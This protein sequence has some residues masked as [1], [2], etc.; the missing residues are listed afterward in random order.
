MKKQHRRF[1]WAFAPFALAAAAALAAFAAGCGSGLLDTEDKDESFYTKRVIVTSDGGLSGTYGMDGRA[2]RVAIT[3]SN[4]NFSR[5]FMSRVNKATETEPIDVTDYFTVTTGTATQLLQSYTFKAITPVTNTLPDVGSTVSRGS[6]TFTA[7][8]SYKICGDD[9]LLE[10]GATS[11]AVKIT[12]SADVLDETTP[13]ECAGS[14]S[15]QFTVPEHELLSPTG[16]ALYWAVRTIEQEKLEGLNAAVLLTTM[17]PVQ[18]DFEQGVQIGTATGGAQVYA[19]KAIQKGSGKIFAVVNNATATESRYTGSVTIMLCGGIL[20][21][22]ETSRN[23]TTH[24]AATTLLG[25]LYG[26]DF[27]ETDGDVD[28]VAVGRYITPK[29]LPDGDGGFALCEDAKPETGWRGAYTYSDNN[30]LW[31]VNYDGSYVVEFDLMLDGIVS[32]DGRNGYSDFYL[33]NSSVDLSNELRANPPRSAMK[34]T[35]WVWHFTGEATWLKSGTMQHYKVYVNY[36][37]AA[38]ASTVTVEVDGKVVETNTAVSGNGDVQGVLLEPA[39]GTAQTIDNI[40]I[41]YASK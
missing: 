6:G 13:L 5:E 1:R 16:S 36:N 15:Y 34:E 41:Y 2:V 17:F 14:I 22:R 40:R 9:K 33:Y 31:K 7:E 11:G 3:V 23:F 38:A 37:Q 19:A 27:D 21:E 29:L 20:D 4:G 8:L 24:D 39:R 26:L 35:S 30:H 32:N 18:K 12:A 25:P 10:G 28:K